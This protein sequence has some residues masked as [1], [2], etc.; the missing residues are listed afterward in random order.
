MPVPIIA[1]GAAAVAAR[2]AAKK[3]AK[4][5]AKKVAAKTTAK[6]AQIAKNSVVK[7]PARKPVGNPPNMTKSTEEMLSSASRGGVGRGSLGKAKTARKFST[8]AGRGKMDVRKPARMPDEPAR[9]TVKINS[10]KTTRVVRVNP[11]KVTSSSRNSLGTKKQALP[12]KFEKVK[13]EVRKQAGLENRGA[14]PT[15]RERINRARDLQWD[16]AEKSY[17]A[18]NEISMTGLK[19]TNQGR[20][21]A[22]GAGKK[23]Q[24]KADA[25]RKEATKENFYERIRNPIKI[26]TNPTKPKGVFGPLKK[27]LA[28]ADTPANRAKTVN[29]TRGLKA[30]NKPVSK[31]NRNRFGDGEMPA[32]LKS[33]KPA[34][35]NR[36]RLGNTAKKS[37]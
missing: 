22:R 28:A 32:Y 25:I 33:E 17:E 19:S 3:L 10:A 23:N 14:K 8:S 36:T 35:A 9:A 20:V 13:S 27:K 29:N 37:K 16:K 11:K 6:T 4:E 1:A 26:N 30:A 21:V 31:N 18:S 7:K 5:A 24:R 15:T 34:R 2:L 12:S